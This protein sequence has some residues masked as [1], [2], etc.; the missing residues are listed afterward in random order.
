[1]KKEM[2]RREFLKDVALLAAATGTVAGMAPFLGCGKSF[3]DNPDLPNIILI[4][5]DDLGWKDLSCYGNRDINTPKIDRLAW[6]GVR[7]TNAFV[8][9]PSCSPSRASLITGQYPHTNGVT[10]LTHRYMTKQ[11]SPFHTTM[12]ELLKKAGYNTAL[13]GKWHVAPYMP[14]SWFGYQEHLSGMLPK[15]WHINDAIKPVEFIRNNSNNRFYLEL[16]FQ[17]NH[18][19]DYGEFAFDP[20]FPVDP[21]KISVPD[22]YT[23]PD[24][25]EIRKDLAKYYSQTLKMDKIIGD[26]LTALDQ[27]ELAENTM[28]IFVSDNGPPYPGNKMTLYD[29]G[30]GTPLMVRWPRRLKAGTTVR[31]LVNSIDIMP[32]VLEAASVS[33]PE[34]V[35]GKSFLS[36]MTDRDSEPTHKAVFTEMT[37]HVHYLPTRAVRTEQ[38]KY[39]KNYSDIAMGL[40]QLNHKEWAHTLCE[41]PNQPWKRP[42]PEEELYDLKKDPHEQKNLAENPKYTP[43]LDKMRSLLKEHQQQTKDPYLGKSFT[44]DY[45]AAMYAPK[46]NE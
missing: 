22:Y 8:V 21:E 40:D 19:D 39:I 41:K 34:D 28:V 3:T 26:I 43:V 32:T 25:L 10:A 46:T 31:H 29:R 20:D 38:Y 4:T 13:Q 27:V 42:R 23:L 12:P 35:Q 33:V 6:E 14:V 17:Q 2:N 45:D 7:F 1:M 30:T 16:N 9:A 11:L 44:H 15:T 18:R 36:M 24:W 5:A 37:Y